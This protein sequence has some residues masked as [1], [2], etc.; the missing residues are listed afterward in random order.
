MVIFY[1]KC[2]ELN[3]AVSKKLLMYWGQEEKNPSTLTS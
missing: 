2:W 3:L 1:N